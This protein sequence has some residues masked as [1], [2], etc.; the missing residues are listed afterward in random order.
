MLEQ[1]GL[2][3]ERLA[4]LRLPRALAAPVRAQP[5]P[6]VQMNPDDPKH[7]WTCVPIWHLTKM[8]TE[9]V[10]H[11]AEVVLPKSFGQKKP[12][13]GAT[14]GRSCCSGPRAAPALPPA[15][16]LRKSVRA[17]VAHQLKASGEAL[18]LRR[19]LRSS[20]AAAAPSANRSSVA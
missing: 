7:K 10:C 8:F 11:A 5:P 17:I 13:K 4:L 14:A 16:R 12:K 15:L 19:L 18:S 2:G 6:Q 9:R 1:A 20:E 3:L